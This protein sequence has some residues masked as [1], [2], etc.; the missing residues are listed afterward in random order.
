MR[1]MRSPEPET[2]DDEEEEE[3]VA[4]ENG[5]HDDGDIALGGPRAARVAAI[6]PRR[7]IA[8]SD[9]DNTPVIILNLIPE[10]NEASRGNRPDDVENEEQPK[11]KR[12]KRN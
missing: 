9:S 12:R 3:D 7:D 2:T 4:A 11:K 1:L 8:D 10:E 5:V 6:W